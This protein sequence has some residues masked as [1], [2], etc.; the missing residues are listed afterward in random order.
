MEFVGWNSPLFLAKVSLTSSSPLPPT[1]LSSGAPGTRGYSALVG[2]DYGATG[3]LGV[4]VHKQGSHCMPHSPRT[5]RESIFNICQMETKCGQGHGLLRVLR[6]AWRIP[7][8]LVPSGAML[9]AAPCFFLGKFQPGCPLWIP[10]PL[11]EVGV[12]VFS[13]KLDYSDTWMR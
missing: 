6:W 3:W 13:A 10:L 11:C 5:W 4:Q 9:R 2:C 7:K 12:T 8:H 1:T